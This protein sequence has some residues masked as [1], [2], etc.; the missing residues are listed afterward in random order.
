MMQD[1]NKKFKQLIE[2]ATTKQ[3]HKFEIL[4][5]LKEEIVE[6]RKRKLSFSKLTEL[7]KQVNMDVSTD[8]VRRFC[9]EVLKKKPRQKQVRQK[10]VPTSD[11]Q[12]LTPKSGMLK[13]K[14]A[15]TL[16]PGFR[17]PSDDL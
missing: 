16:P 6:A 9:Q 7:L 8:T 3:S 1:I 14:G 11:K 12:R 5:Q 10:S 15:R 4:F 13:L 17:V 2:A